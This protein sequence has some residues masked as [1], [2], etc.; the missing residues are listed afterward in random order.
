[1][2][3]KTINVVYKVDD[4]E[5][6]K[7]KTTIQGAEKETEK[8]NAELKKTG[9]S[10]KKAGA[11]GS[12]SFL[13]FKNVVASIGFAGLAFAIGSVA[14]KI[15]DL[16]V[17]QE[18]TNIAFTT[19]LGSAEKAKKLIAELNK[20]ALITPFT[21][22]QVNKAAQTLLAFG[23]QGEEVIDTLKFL[24]DVSSGTGKDL[25]EMAVIFGQIRS[26]GRL[27]G[28]DLLQLIN[29]GFNPLQIISQKTGR[30]MRDLKKDM[31]NGL[32]S[33]DQVQDAFKTATS[34]GGLFFNLMEKQ[35]QSIGGLMSTI[36][37][38]VEEIGKKLFEARQGGLSDFAQGVA[39]ATGETDLW[40]EA[41]N[42][43][44]DKALEAPT[45]TLKL[46]NLLKKSIKEAADETAR[47]RQEEIALELALVEAELQ[48]FQTVRSH[49]EKVKLIQR[50]VDLRAQLGLKMPTTEDA[51]PWATKEKEE[52]AV[53]LV[54]ALEIKIKQ[55][56]EQIRATTKTDD[57]G[58]DGL[59][60]KQLKETKAE[61]DKLLGNESGG[62]K[63][64]KKALDEYKKQLEAER[65]AEEDLKERT[66]KSR[67]DRERDSAKNSADL[68]T[69]YYNLEKQKLQEAEDEKFKI[70]ED[71]ARKRMDLEQE[72]RQNAEMLAYAV[73]DTALSTK[74]EDLDAISSYYDEQ[75]ELAGDNERAQKELRVKRDRDIE[76]ARQR[77][78]VA[79]K[80]EAITRIL[81]DGA[82]T[83]A[84][85]FRDYGWPGGIIPAALM[86][87]VTATQIAAV[88]KYKDGG[89]VKGPGGETED[90]VP[91]LASPNEFVVKARSAKQSPRLLELINNRKI[92]DRILKVASGGGSFSDSRMVSELGAIRKEIQ[93]N[94]PDDVIELHGKLMRATKRGKDYV[95]YMKTNV[96]GDF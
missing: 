85:I 38:N 18:Q 30:S 80:R 22:A 57:L 93:K 2:A 67:R 7:V 6:R 56:Q 90:R 1:V 21:P 15:F 74:E 71:A 91:I 81:I 19:F 25:S 17:V 87:A 4:G 10:A 28:Q 43:V 69:Y 66:D 31:E 86:A 92:D 5:L 46:F 42:S 51:L 96:M 78:K 54:E 39:E 32:I 64:R 11:E 82:V 49:T 24:G 94:R 50:M 45:A 47:L 84:K 53:G 26:T 52:I 35:S 16:G 29:A 65:K 60:V 48:S 75:I 36:E 9:D 3:K 12:K 59:L 83:I 33:F 88:Q 63:S 73:L 20:F 37:G 55:L 70:A 68:K 44:I 34:E 62:D 14:K 79:E 27:M 61:L 89:W 13:D 58:K 77:Q 23:V 41:I 8:L 72:I 40:A 95:M 76:L